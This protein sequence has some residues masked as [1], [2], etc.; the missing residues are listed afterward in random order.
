MRGYFGIGI[1]SGKYEVNIGTLWRSAY[2]L[3]A[4]FIFIINRRYKKQCSDTMKVWRHIPLLQFETFEDF[5]SMIAY[6]C[7]IVCV[8]FN[9]KSENLK[10]FK[11]PERCIYL[12]GAEDGGIP[13]H[14]YKEYKTI[15]IP[16][17][18]QQS[19]NV[20][21][22]GTIVMYDRFIKK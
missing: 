14:I 11:H 2:Q 7:P 12:L 10:D 5:K 21:M 17:Q 9:D 6:D 8:E 4:S 16:S 1:Y 22:A 15:E 19:Y 18:R 13:K 3:G 20:A